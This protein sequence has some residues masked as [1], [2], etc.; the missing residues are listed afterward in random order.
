VS[1]RARA[2]S[3]RVAGLPAWAIT[4]GLGVLYLIIAPHSPDLAA[5]SYRSDLFNHSGFTLWDNSWYGGHHLPAYSILAPPLGALIGPR[6]LAA[7]SMTIATALFPAILKD[8]FSR[9]AIRWASVWLAIGA[10]VSLLS[11]RVPFDLGLA[12][13][14]AAVLL[15]LRGQLWPALLLSVICSLSSPVAGA[16]LALAFLAC[17]LAG[18]TRAWPAALTLAALVPIGLL[19]V[20]FPEGGSQPF[21]ASAFYPALLGAV[22]VGVLVGPEQRSLRIGAVLYGIALVGSYLIPTAVGGNADRLGSLFAGPIAPCVLAAAPRRSRRGMAL[23]VLTPFLL[24]WQVNAP[25]ADFASSSSN[26]SVRSAYYAPLLGEL[27]NLGVGYGAHPARIEAVPTSAHWEA[28]WLAPHVML[29]RG[30]ERQ[31]DRYRNEL[32]YDESTTLTAASYRAWL[33]EN[34]ISYVALPDANLDYSAGGEARLLRGALP[35]YLHEIWR[36]AHW[37]LFGVLHPQPLISSP[38]S[39]SGLSEDSFTAYLPRA[40]DYTVRVHFTP[41]WALG[42]GSG[43]ISRAA[44]DWTE[45]QAHRPGYLGVVIRF[46]LG[47]I[48][49]QGPRCN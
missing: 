16:F 31:L 22:V 27:H 33:T 18:Q 5:A 49:S 37:R 14:L 45:I 10:S 15:A 29:A 25:L 13:G 48:F 46:S 7:I 41:Y 8:R 3:R 30:W 6:P 24:Y 17:G 11:S 26:P 21:V 28:R 20:I 36:S 42:S 2:L 35:S 47:R 12:V 38:G 40:G 1:G 43:C 39:L 9:R 23:L 32:F 19:T 44:G 34:S 4:A